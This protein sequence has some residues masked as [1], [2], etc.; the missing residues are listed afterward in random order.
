MTLTPFILIILAVTAAGLGFIVGLAI[1]G[2]MRESARDD[3]YHDGYVAGT[4][5]KP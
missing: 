4:K 2:A 3:E 5:V 1:G